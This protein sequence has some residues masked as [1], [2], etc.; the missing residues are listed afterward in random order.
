MLV[1]LVYPSQCAYCRDD[2]PATADDILL[3]GACRQRMSPPVESWCPRC[4]APLQ[5]SAGWEHD[6]V[7]CKDQKFEWG[8]AVALARYQGD[9]SRAIVRMKSAHAEPLTV[10]LA[11]RLFDDRGEAI[12]QLRAELVVPM[13][14]HWARRLVRGVNSPELIAEVLAQRLGLPMKM[15]ALRRRRLTPLQTELGRQER[16]VNQRHSFRA[17]GRAGLAGRRVLLVDDVLTTGA[18]ADEAGRILREAGAAA[19]FVAVI[20]RAVGDDVA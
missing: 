13:P 11:R 14:M 7:H 19:V 6:C 12:T 1:D 9:L 5:G 10:A 3:C 20:A 18:T 17:S 8:A 4:S 16:H 15:R 2:L